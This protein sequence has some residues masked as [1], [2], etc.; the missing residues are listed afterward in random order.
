MKSGGHAGLWPK[1]NIN[2]FVGDKMNTDAARTPLL[3][4]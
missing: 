2:R 4:F 1:Q 3:T